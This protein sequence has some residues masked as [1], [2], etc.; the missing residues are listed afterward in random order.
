MM[1]T[2]TRRILHCYWYLF[3]EGPDNRVDDRLRQRYGSTP[4]CFSDDFQRH[5]AVTACLGFEGF[6]KHRPHVLELLLLMCMPLSWSAHLYMYVCMYVCMDTHTH[7]HTRVYMPLG[8]WTSLAGRVQKSLMSSWLHVCVCV[9]VRAC[10][11]A[12]HTQ[13]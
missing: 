2:C 9:L 1:Q 3:L 8:F 11:C 7:T 10:M 13:A 5:L 12:N 6:L 4:Q